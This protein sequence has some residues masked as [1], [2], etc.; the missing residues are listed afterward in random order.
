ML[1]H[2]PFAPD[3][4]NSSTL[5]LP[6]HPLT[7]PTSSTHHQPTRP[8]AS[9]PSNTP[10]CNPAA[11]ASV[12]YFGERINTLAA[13]HWQKFATQ[14]YFD[15]NGAFFS[16][17]VSLPLVF[18]LFTVLV[19]GPLIGSWSATAWLPACLCGVHAC[20][21]R[22]PCWNVEASIEWVVGCSPGFECSLS[23][24]CCVK[25]AS[26]LHCVLEGLCRFLPGGTS[27]GKGVTL[28]KHTLTSNSPL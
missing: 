3:C 12:I 13:A 26:S 27:L 22:L 16:A 6:I 10:H 24:L 2:L 5:D 4:R 8:P 19:G 23:F 11:A 7:P 21:R 18:T 28:V 14:A 20:V 1:L 25:F 15:P 9:P 17:L